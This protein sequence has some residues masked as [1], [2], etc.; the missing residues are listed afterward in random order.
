M[1]RLVATFLVLTF[2]SIAAGAPAAEP[3]NPWHVDQKSEPSRTFDVADQVSAGRGAAGW[4]SRIFA[5][6]QLMPNGV[7]GIGMFG[8]KAEKGP[9]DPTIGRDLSLRKQRKASVGFSLRF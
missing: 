2:T 6:K 4:G 8:P 1:A 9:H 5:G 3:S 7:I